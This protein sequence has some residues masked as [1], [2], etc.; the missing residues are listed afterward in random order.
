LLLAS[1]PLLE[2]GE[3]APLGSREL[4]AFE[5]EGVELRREELEATGAEVVRRFAIM[6][7]FVAVA[8]ESGFDL[9]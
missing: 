4:R 1:R 3:L 8:S 6:G 5:F 2:T 9:Q 7:L